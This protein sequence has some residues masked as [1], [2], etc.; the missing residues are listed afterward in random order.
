MESG[1]LVTQRHVRLKPSNDLVTL[2]YAVPEDTVDQTLARV[3]I[4]LLLGVLG[5]TVLALL[6]GP[7]R[8]RAGDV[9]DQGADRGGA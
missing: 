8:V 3:Q 6:A 1:Y 4:F 7:V 9:A 5:G 2:L